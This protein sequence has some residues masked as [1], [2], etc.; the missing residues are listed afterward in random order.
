[1]ADGH[2][3]SS[4]RTD[5]PD[6]SD[7]NP[8]ISSLNS[9]FPPQQGS[10]FGMSEQATRCDPGTSSGFYSA[11][12]ELGDN[13]VHIGDNMPNMHTQLV[14][15]NSGASLSEATISAASDSEET[16]SLADDSGTESDKEVQQQLDWQR[17][18]ELNLAAREQEDRELA[19]LWKKNHQEWLE[20]SKAKWREQRSARRRFLGIFPKTRKNAKAPREPKPPREPKAPKP[21]KQLKAAKPPGQSRAYGLKALLDAGLVE[22][23]PEKLSLSIRYKDETFKAALLDTGG[24]VWKTDD[25]QSLEFA[26][27]SAWSIF[28]KRIVTPEKKADDGWKSVKYSNGC[29]TL[30]LEAL[31]ERLAMQAY[32]NAVPTPD[33]NEE[34]HGTFAV[35]SEQEPQAMQHDARDA[36]LTDEDDEEA[37]DPQHQGTAVNFGMDVAYGAVFPGGPDASMPV[38]GGTW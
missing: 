26:S 3:Q 25:G 14:R 20:R 31:K 12:A 9:Y 35:Q 17:H 33:L 23:D 30:T 18:E 27:P 2:D 6:H 37:P 22:A 38:G 15:E 11:G 36:D 8:E 24:I 7:A 1:M 10:L 4:S 32:N 5:S 13:A 34:T 28:V 21:P 19:A 16:K 29:S